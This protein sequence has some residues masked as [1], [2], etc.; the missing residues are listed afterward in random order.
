MLSFP[1]IDPV[2]LQLGPLAIRWY[3]LAYI[4]GIL[5]GWW[6]I[7]AEH[8]KRPLANLTRKAIDDMVMYA[9]LGIILGG[10]LGYTLFYKPGYYLEHPLQI[11]HVWEGGM[12][13]HGGLAGFIIAFYLFARRHNISFLGLMDLMAVA[14]P[15]GLFFGRVA[16]FINGELYG[17]VTDS[18]LGMIFPGGGS[19]PRHPSQ[20]YEAALEGIVL[21]LLLLILLKTTRLREKTGML[22]GIFMSGYGIARIV[23]EYFREPDAFLGYLM[24]GIT[25]G[26]LLSL[27]VL[28]IGVYLIARKKPSPLGGEGWVG[29]NNNRVGGEK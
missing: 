11:L 21:F 15:I 29:G 25:M 19:L 22:S 17:R 2:A 27:P 8:K 20:L 24:P 16:N 13:F 26:Q 10:R 23:C 9:V 7:L 18:P 12:S 6:L 1:S 14:A 5:L 3:S 4:A 28:L